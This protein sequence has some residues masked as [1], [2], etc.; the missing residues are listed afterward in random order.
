MSQQ[1]PFPIVHTT[2]YQSQ[3][4]THFFIIRM[5][6]IPVF[7]SCFAFF[8]SL[9]RSFL[10]LSFSLS[11]FIF[12]AASFLW[13]WVLNFRLRVRLFFYVFRVELWFFVR[14][15]FP[16]PFLLRFTFFF[17]FCLFWGFFHIMLLVSHSVSPFFPF[18]SFP[19]SYLTSST[20]IP[21]VYQFDIMPSVHKL[22]F[23]TYH[24][25]CCIP[26]KERQYLC[27]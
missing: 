19:G 13:S 11:L 16:V 20:G 8:S 6:Y 5:S 22:T 14:S 7:R 10:L 25:N 3:C 9:F 2:N 26:M 27:L 1:Y 21:S 23:S 12:C 15:F 24:H 17:V 18:F 4:L